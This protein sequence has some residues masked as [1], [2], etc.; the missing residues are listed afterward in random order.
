MNEEFLLEL[1]AARVFVKPGTGI[2]TVNGKDHIDYFDT[3]EHRL[4]SLAGLLYPKLMGKYDVTAFVNGGGKTGQAGAMRVA[5][6]WAVMRQEP[7]A[8]KA[9]FEDKLYK[10]DGRSVERKKFGKPKARKS[11]AFVKR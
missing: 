2:V 3:A 7:S 5:L 6:A 4:E 9:M 1:E 11:F 10:P 8:R